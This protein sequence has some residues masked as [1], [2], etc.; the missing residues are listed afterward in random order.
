MSPRVEGWTADLSAAYAHGDDLE[1]GVPLDSIDPTRVVLGLRYAGAD[2]RLRLGALVTASAGK[3]RVDMTRPD[4]LR[5]DGFVALDLTVGWTF[6]DTWQVDA[7]VFNVANASYY[8]W[9]DVRGRPAGDP[10]LELYRR[11]GR[12]WRVAVSASW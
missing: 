5:L 2:A 6:S 3:R 7:G 10:L 1:R 12:S 8:E 11:P 9:A 4:P